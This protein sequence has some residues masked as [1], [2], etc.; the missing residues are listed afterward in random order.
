LWHSRCKQ[1]RPWRGRGGVWGVWDVGTTSQLGARRRHTS[2]VCANGVAFVGLAG[3]ISLPAWPAAG[4]SARTMAGNGA[5]LRA[6]GTTPVAPQR[7]GQTFTTCRVFPS[8][9]RQIAEPAELPFRIKRIY[10][11]RLRNPDGTARNLKDLL[12]AGS[13]PVPFP[14]PSQVIECKDQFRRFRW[15][16]SPATPH[17]DIAFVRPCEQTVALRLLQHS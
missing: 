11:N 10:R 16:L 4:W 2:R 5:R 3:G 7:A 12:Q 17:D 15:F 13:V 14:V 6:V 1:G 8:S 9:V